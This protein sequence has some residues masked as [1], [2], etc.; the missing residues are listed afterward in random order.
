[1]GMPAVLEYSEKPQDWKTLWPK[2]DLPW[3]GDS[4]VPDE[5]GY[6]PK[7]DG[8]A[9]FRRRSEVTPQTWALVYQQEDVSEDNIFPPAIVQG[10]INGQRK[11]GL[12][13]AG[14]VG[15]PRNIEGYTIIGFDPA[16][17]GNAAF[18]VA[19]YNR[20]DSRI[21]VLDCVNM[22]DP[23]PQKI[24]DI[25][26]HLSKIILVLILKILQTLF[27]SIYDLCMQ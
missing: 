13:K 4:D 10:C 27:I 15:H 16:M 7:W 11:R 14:A 24:Q 5:E 12:L 18:V 6:F 23:T 26:E 22:S 3:D 2:S 1:M 20:A 19:T 8:K 17:G 25:I 21:Y 9:L